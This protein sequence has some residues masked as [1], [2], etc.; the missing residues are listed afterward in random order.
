MSEV[1]REPGPFRIRKAYPARSRREHRSIEAAET[2]AQRLQAL[3]PE[4]SFVIEQE[5]ARVVPNG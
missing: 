3:N 1:I 5:V 4:Q 2:E